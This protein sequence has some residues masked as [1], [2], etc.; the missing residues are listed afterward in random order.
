[1]VAAEKI[2]NHISR[3]MEKIRSNTEYGIIYQIRYNI[4]NAI[5]LFINITIAKAQVQYHTCCRY[6]LVF[7]KW[8]TILKILH[9]P[10]E[11]DLKKLMWHEK[12]FLTSS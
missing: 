11:S 10:S 9:G 5:A 8:P 1:M 6:E 4:F 3:C 2:E 12:L 7:S